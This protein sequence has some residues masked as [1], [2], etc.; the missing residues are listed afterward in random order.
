MNVY[1][2]ENLHDIIDGQLRPIEDKTFE[3]LW[4]K[5]CPD[6]EENEVFDVP[7]SHVHLPVQALVDNTRF[8]V[9]E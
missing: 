1:S 7:W 9:C 3:V 2:M 5:L 8:L 4:D 6:C